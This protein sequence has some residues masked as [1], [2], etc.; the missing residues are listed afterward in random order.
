MHSLTT[1][2]GADVIV[3]SADTLEEAIKQRQELLTMAKRLKPDATL[4][5]RNVDD[6]DFFEAVRKVKNNRTGQYVYWVRKVSQK[7]SG[8]LYIDANEPWS[9]YDK[10]TDT[11]KVVFQHPTDALKEAGWDFDT[12]DDSANPCK[13]PQLATRKKFAKNA[14]QESLRGKTMYVPA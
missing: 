6:N 8:E 5:H 3:T 7:K 13:T 9:N 14:K 12:E 10:E 1:K 11:T 4:Q 2:V